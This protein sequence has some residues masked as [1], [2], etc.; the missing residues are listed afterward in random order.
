MW[1]PSSSSQHWCSRERSEL[2]Q[3]GM[4]AGPRNRVAMCLLERLAEAIQAQEPLQAIVVLPAHPEGSLEDPSVRALMHYQY[5]T[6][7][8]DTLGAGGFLNQLQHRVGPH[9]DLAQHIGF[10]CLHQHGF[11]PDGRAV[12]S[13]VYVHSK[14]LLVDDQVAVVG[15]ANIND[16]SMLG[17]RDSEVCVRVAAEQH[18]PVGGFRERLCRVHLGLPQDAPVPIPGL[19]QQWHQVAASNTCALSKAFQAIPGPQLPTVLSWSRAQ[20][21][22]LASKLWSEAER[23]R[24]ASQVRGFAT[25]FPHQFLAN[26]DLAPRLGDVEFLVPRETF[27]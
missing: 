25:L 17:S 8:R 9:V 15:S 3:E 21:R 20:E 24:I 12:L 14:L 16:R 22:D 19:L 6:T 26:Q 5:G 7:S 2:L 13:Q 4:E 1:S 18:E 23:E 10:F 27:L 11:T